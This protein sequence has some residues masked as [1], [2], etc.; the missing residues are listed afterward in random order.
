VL[1]VHEAF[2][3]N[4]GKDAKELVLSLLALLV[5]ILLLALLVQEPRQGCQG[6]GTQFTCFTSTKAQILTPGE[7]QEE[8]RVGDLACRKS[9]WLSAT[10][11]ACMV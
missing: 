11:S 5:Q 6:A 7:L 1:L 3:K 2:S 10:S 8:I 4:L 9:V